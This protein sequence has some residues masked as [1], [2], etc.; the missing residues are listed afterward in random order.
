MATS[1][2]QQVRKFSMVLALLA[3]ERTRHTNG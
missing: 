1:Q 2:L 3:M